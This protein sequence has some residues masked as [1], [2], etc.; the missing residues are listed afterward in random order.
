MSSWMK[1]NQCLTKAHFS[2]P[3]LRINPFAS[4]VFV[5]LLL[6]H[7]YNVYSHTKACSCNSSLSFEDV[8]T[9]EL[10]C[11]IHLVREAGDSACCSL[12]AARL[13]RSFFKL[14][15]CVQDSFKILFCRILHILPHHSN[16]VFWSL[17]SLT[18]TFMSHHEVSG[19]FWRPKWFM[20]ALFGNGFSFSLE[21]EQA[22]CSYLHGT[23]SVINDHA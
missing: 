19:A 9:V 1:L 10:F 16:R 8:R 12:L 3:I 17:T 14:S 11:T 22:I 15:F 23:F 20:A 18:V 7:A 5:Y 2:Y 21:T 6:L 4:S 13:H